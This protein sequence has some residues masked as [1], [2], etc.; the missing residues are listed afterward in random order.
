MNTKPLQTLLVD[1]IHPFVDVSLPEIAAAAI[2]DSFPIRR[3]GLPR[4]EALVAQPLQHIRTDL[5]AL[6]VS[7]ILVSIVVALVVVFLVV[8]QRQR[9]R[10]VPPQQRLD[11]LP[12]A[13]AHVHLMV[14]IRRTDGLVLG[15]PGVA[16][17]ALLVHLPPPFRYGGVRL[18]QGKVG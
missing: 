14:A 13:G 11:A 6:L 12:N 5:V 15:D 9:R 10:V 18:G 3:L 7:G 2:L 8:S 16:Q 17:P 1:R 4:R